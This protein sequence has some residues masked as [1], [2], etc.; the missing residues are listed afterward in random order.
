VKNAL[1]FVF[2]CASAYAFSFATDC[3]VGGLLRIYTNAGFPAATWVVIAM[4]TGLVALRLAPQGRF[5]VIPFA[6]ITLLALFS[7]IVGRRYNL[8]VAAVM[9]AESVGVWLTTRP[10]PDPC[11]PVGQ[12]RIDAV[13]DGLRGLTPLSAAELA[14]LNAA[15]H[16]EGE[17]VWHAPAAEF[18]GLQWDTFIGTV[19]SA[20]Y[21]ISIQWT[22]PRHQTGATYRQ[23]VVHCT[24]HY[25]RGE[26]LTVWNA[27]NGN[28]VVLS[29]NVG[30]EG[31]LTVTVTSRKVRQFKRLL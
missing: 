11:F 22:G 25:G 18:M 26:N 14:A 12:Y 9:L 1:A 30:D 5:L 31:I 7:G 2:A 24:K 28:I 27:S 16:F 10:L 15:V 13:I 29:E 20:I 19:S 4:I 3:L 21:K 6:L 8:T 17:Q 23:I